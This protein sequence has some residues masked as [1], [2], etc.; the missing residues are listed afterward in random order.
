[1]ER[2]EVRR[3]VD[4]GATEESG[5]R[6]A[7]PINNAHSR[8][9]FSQGTTS[10]SITAAAEGA[11]SE[12]SPLIDDDLANNSPF[13]ASRTPERR[14]AISS[15]EGRRRHQRRSS[16]KRNRFHAA[17]GGSFGPDESPAH[18]LEGVSLLERAASSAKRARLRAG[19]ALGTADNAGDEGDEYCYKKGDYDHGDGGEDADF[20]YYDEDAAAYGEEEDGGVSHYYYQNEGSHNKSN[21]ASSLSSSGVKLSARDLVNSARK[22]RGHNF[23][24][25]STTSNLGSEVL[26]IMPE[27]AFF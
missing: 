9:S 12:H 1:M 26:F 4:Y 25:S 14:S 27:A 3:T 20:Y 8:E 2:G 17:A 7:I 15:P 23:L 11:H 13:I 5:D 10:I 21:A 18:D 6:E 24:L 16:L 22:R 19:S